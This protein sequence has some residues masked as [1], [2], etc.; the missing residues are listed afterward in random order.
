M[1][2]T[3][4]KTQLDDDQKDDNLTAKVEKGIYKAF[5]S[6]DP[7]KKTPIV[8]IE[9]RFKNPIQAV[10][11]TITTTNVSVT[12]GAKRF[13]EMTTEVFTDEEKS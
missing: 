7:G 13:W 12:K 4:E 11:Q 6:S 1:E 8:K 3:N 2:R 10:A 5:S 9:P